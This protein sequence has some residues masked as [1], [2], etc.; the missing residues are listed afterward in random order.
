MDNRK[1]FEK[2]LKRG[3]ASL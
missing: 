2:H 3:F 1:Y